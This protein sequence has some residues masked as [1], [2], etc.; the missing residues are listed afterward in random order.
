MIPAAGAWLTV[1]R[2]RG[3]DSAEGALAREDEANFWLNGNL[4]DICGE[5]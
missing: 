5:L 4:V 3:A 1:A 2:V